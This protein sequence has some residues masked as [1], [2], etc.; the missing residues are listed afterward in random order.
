MTLLTGQGQLGWS[1]AGRSGAEPGRR[2]SSLE[3][4]GHSHA[5]S[6]RH[7]GSKCQS[8]LAGLLARSPLVQARSRAS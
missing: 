7:F 3:R 2:A 5:Q 4:S 8:G 6:W 1:W